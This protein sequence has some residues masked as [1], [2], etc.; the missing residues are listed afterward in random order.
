M[1]GQAAI[2]LAV[3]RIF[4]EM[5]ALR[6]VEPPPFRTIAECR[7]PTSATVACRAS[8]TSMAFMPVITQGARWRA[9]CT[10]LP[11]FPLITVDSDLF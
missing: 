7:R 2:A 3:Y 4:N 9:G 8:A 10:R 6:G 11:S 1:D 5:M